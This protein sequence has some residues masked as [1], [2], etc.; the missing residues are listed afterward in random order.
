MATVNDLLLDSFGR[1]RDVVHR[2]LD[3]VPADDLASPPAPGTNTIAWL[4]W[5]LTRVVDDHTA[6]AFGHDQ[7]WTSDG[8]YERFALPF[9]AEAHG[10]GMSFDE[11]LAVTPD[12]AQLRGY[13]D[14]VDAAA[15]RDLT[16][17][18]EADLDRVVDT[19]WDPPV[20]LA[21]RLISLINDATQHAAQAAYAAGILERA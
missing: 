14:A 9:P 20:T 8:W 1:V 4:L 6:D 3:E 17:V 10:Y 21:V 15:V 7:V 18:T 5:H 19:R 13:F 2:V 16:A 12:A 11:V